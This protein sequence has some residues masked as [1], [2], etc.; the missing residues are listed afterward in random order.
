[1]CTGLYLLEDTRVLTVSKRSLDTSVSISSA[2][3]AALTGVPIGGSIKIS[4]ET[5]L[6]V[7]SASEEQLVWAAQYRKLDAKYIRL[8]DGE[9]ATLP[10]I[11]TLYQDVTSDGPLRKDDDEEMNAVQIDVI[12]E[13][14][15]EA[16][17]KEGDSISEEVYYER[18]EKAIREFEV[19]LED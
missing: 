11:L 8:R 3:T 9:T 5:S 13:T 17:E 16:Q 12:G 19:E 18:L 7:S 10:N 1:M 14:D 2:T 15:E 4:P 6:T